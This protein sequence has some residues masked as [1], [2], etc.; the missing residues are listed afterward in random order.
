M[1]GAQR[2]LSRRLTRAS[3]PLRF[4]RGTDLSGL[5]LPD[6]R[7]CSFCQFKWHIVRSYWAVLLTT[8]T[9]LAIAD[10]L[11]IVAVRIKHPGRIIARIVFEPSL[12]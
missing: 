3:L 10:D 1:I 9:A 8:V 6:I 5:R 4:P 7:T 12:R 2:H 11:D